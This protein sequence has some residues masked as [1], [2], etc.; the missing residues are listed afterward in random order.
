M[1]LNTHDVAHCILCDESVLLAEDEAVEDVEDVEDDLVLSYSFKPRPQFQHCNEPSKLYFGV[2]TE[3]NFEDEYTKDCVLKTIKRAERYYLRDGLFY[4]KYDGSLHYGIECVSHPATLGFWKKLEEKEQLD[5]YFSLLRHFG[6]KVKVCSEDIYYKKVYTAGLHVH[7]SSKSMTDLHKYR[8]HLF[9]NNLQDYSEVI[10]RREGNDYAVYYGYETYR[11]NLKE[12]VEQQTSRDS[13]RYSAVNWT[14]RD[15]VEVRIFAA[16]MNVTEYLTA[17]E[18][19]HAVYQYTKHCGI[20]YL[21]NNEKHIVWAHFL[22][23]IE[24][25]KRYNNLCAFVRGSQE[26]TADYLPGQKHNIK[27]KRREKTCA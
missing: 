16:A 2:E 11:K 6:G 7:I 17:I 15:T 21:L 8:F 14:N 22:K 25:D 13:S 18:Y 26:L 27:R 24:H 5:I 9:I 1:L 23:F 12:Y 4:L 3:I 10:A 19:C 20:G